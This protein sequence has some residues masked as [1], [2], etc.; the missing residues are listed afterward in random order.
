MGDFD[1][2]GSDWM[3]DAVG[4]MFTNVQHY[5]PVE[6]CEKFMYMPGGITK[7]PGLMSFD[8][9]PYWREPLNC[10]DPRSD[11]REINL[12]KGVQ[13][14]AT[15]L[16]VA[17]MFY[18]C[19]HVAHKNL[20]Y[21]SKEKE[22]ATDILENRLIPI[23]QQSGFE[24]VI[25][26]VEENNTRKKGKNKNFLQIMGG[27]TLYYFGANN[28]GKMRQITTGVIFKDELSGWSRNVGVDGNSDKL[29][30]SRADTLWPDRKI[31]RASTPL[32]KPDMTQ[33]A[34]LRGDQRLWQVPC[35]SCGYMHVLQREIIDE[36]T[37]LVGGLSFEL[38]DYGNLVLD[39][40]FYGCPKCGHNHQ[41]YDKPKMF[42]QGEWVPTAEPIEPG[43]RSYHLPGIY[44]PAGNKPWSKVIGEYLEAFDPKQNK[45]RDIGKMQHYYNNTL[46]RPFEVLGEKISHSAASQHRRTEY[47]RGQVPNEF[48]KRYCDSKIMYITC[49]VDVHKRNLAV[50]VMGWTR[51]Q[52]CFL[53]DYW[54]FEPIEEKGEPLCT[55]IKSPTW[56]RLRE[57]IEN[58]EYVADDGAT[59]KILITLIDCRYAG[60]TVFTFCSEYGSGVYPIQGMPRVSARSLL[61]EFSHFETPLGTIGYRLQVD[62]YKDRIAP[63]L[64][65][66]WVSDFGSQSMYHFNAPIDT[67]TQELD[68]F[69][70]EFKATKDTP[71]G[72]YSYWHRTADNELWDLL[73]YGHAAVEIHAF[74]LCRKTLELDTV[75]WVDYWNYVEN[76][77]NAAMFQRIDPQIT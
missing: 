5:T 69:T 25:K 23:L 71:S 66:F 68:E 35:L 3:V 60:P 22:L 26:P 34:Y 56:Q 54:R 27:M 59:Y 16:M 53:I 62:Y 9:F 63:V 17:G 65:K 70:K 76:P 67:T 7:S 2:I 20:L 11:V 10:L 6:F 52:R 19:C 55:D 24:H 42:A 30:D 41:E 33:E 21:I 74:Q 47:V 58:K 75:N 31:F 77:V 32:I 73:V 72:T 48:A 15:T 64:R 36:E 40:V 45:V 13:V 44:S 28:A 46:G 61:K 14:G 38:D 37:G 57:L 43:I 39:S 8:N 51:G 50:S 18:Y 29:T 4:D 12:L 49:T 1:S